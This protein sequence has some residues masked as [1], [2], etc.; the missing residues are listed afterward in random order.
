MTDTPPEGTPP[1]E[2]PTPPATPPADELAGLDDNARMLVERANSE[3][4]AMRHNLRESQ[5][6]LE[7]LQRK[8]ESEQEKM[9]REAEDRGRQAANVDYQQAI[10]GY[11]RRL[12]EFAI[13]AR[14]AERF[15][16][17]GDA[18][19]NLAVDEIV[20]ETDQQRRYEKIDKA[21]TT[22]LE[23]K[24]YLGRTSIV[25]RQPLVTQGGRSE[26]PNGKSRDRQWLR[27]GVQR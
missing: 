11:E 13:V 23:Q 7:A 1:A 25:P 3:A 6:A 14:A 19:L 5:A 12:A 8:H 15:N 2:P 24:P 22:L 20:A 9:I 18:V 26:P 17:P 10:T 27:S 16:D 21:L 4:A